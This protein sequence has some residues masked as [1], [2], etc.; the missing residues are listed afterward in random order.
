MSLLRTGTI[1]VGLSTAR[2]PFRSP[3]R[4]GTTRKRW[5]GPRLP[6]RARLSFVA[7]ARGGFLFQHREA[8]ASFYLRHSPSLRRFNHLLDQAGTENHLGSHSDSPISS[9]R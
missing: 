5:D 7:R 4:F 6:C 2:R 1:S 3:S 8:P 9:T